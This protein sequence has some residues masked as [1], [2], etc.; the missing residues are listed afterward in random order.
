MLDKN[1]DKFSLPE[2]EERVL[3][4]WKE[5]RIF[6]K[7][8]EK[9]KGKKKF[10]FFEGPPT[11]NGRPG[12]HHVL[13]RSFKDLMPRYKTMRG[14]EVPRKAGWDT[15]G[16]P[17][18][19]QAEKELGLESKKDIDKYGIA[20]FNA[21][22]RE[23]VWRYRNEFEGVTD[24]MGFWIDMEDPYVTYDNRYVESLWWVISKINDRK[25]LV[26]GHRVAP[27][28]SRCGT[29][30]SSHE[31]AQGYKEKKSN[32]VYV[33]FAVKKGQKIGK[34]FVADDKTYL[35]S[36]TT[37][38][39]TLPGNVALAVGKNIDYKLV[40]KGDEKFI[41]SYHGGV[42][43]A[44]GEVDENIADLQ[45]KDLIGLSYKPLFDVK[46]L[47]NKKSHKVYA[48]D[49][50]TDNEG[51]GI[52]HTA[53]MYGEDDYALGV[54]ENLPQYHT[55]SED[56]KYKKDVVGFSGK[57]V[58]EA[59][60]EETI[61][62]FL[63]KNKAFLK[64]QEYPH[65]YPHCWRC[66]TPLLY[67]ARS[68]WFVQMSKLKKDLI[69]ANNKVSWT[70]SHIKQGRFGEWLKDVKDW[71]FSRARYWGTPLPIWE[72]LNTR[73]EHRQVVSGFSDLYKHR[74]STNSYFGLRHGESEHNVG[75]QMVAS[76]P[77]VK[78]KTSHLT[79]KGVAQAEEMAKK[80]KKEKIQVI[81]A[82]P[83]QR[84]QK[85]A[86][87]IAKATKAKVITDKRLGEWNTGVFNWKKHADF[88][89]FF[90]NDLERFT[91]APKGGETLTDIQSRAMEFI[92][93][94]DKKYKNKNILI[95]THADVLWLLEGSLRGLSTPEELLA[96]DYY[97]SV[98]GGY[99]YKEFR[100]PHL[101]YNEGGQVDV[102]RP[103]IDAVEL[104]CSKCK[105]NMRRVLELA[106]VWFDSGAMPLA[107]HQFPFV[108]GDN[109]KG[110]KLEEA[111]KKLDFPADYICEAIDQ[112]RGWF[113]TLLA[114]STLLER[115]L[116]YK[117]VV[118]LGL[119][120]DKNGIKMSKSKG[121]IVLP[122]EVMGKYGADAVRLYFYTMNH[123]G[124]AK[125][126]NE[127]ELAK[128]GRR[129]LMIIYNTYVFLKTYGTNDPVP[130][131]GFSPK[132]VL[133]RWIISSVGVLTNN[134]TKH[135]EAYEIGEAAR[136]MEDFLADLSR[137]YVRRSRSRFQEAA[138]GN[139][140]LEKDLREASTTLRYVLST[141]AKLMAPFTPFFAEALYKSVDSRGESVHLESW[142]SFEKKQIDQDLL[143]DMAIVR[144]V[145]A[146]ALAL[147]A[148]NGLKVR[149]PL[150][151]LS[152]KDTSLRGKKELLEILMEEVNVRTIKFSSAIKAES[153]ILL[154]TELTGELVE[155]GIIREL[156][157]MIQSL[158]AEAKY[159][160]G[161]EIVLMISAPEDLM[162][163]IQR[164][165]V[166]LKK[167]VNAKA[168]ELH[169]GA[170][171][172]AMIETKLKD[173]EISIAVR[174][175]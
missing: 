11:A 62:A 140:T 151:S 9:N 129:F 114:T 37:T 111:Y 60:T 150:A 33:K 109:L 76:G 12:I 64:V 136:L 117:N 107:A 89:A 30:L 74:A 135:L 1:P 52:V 54:S 25:L 139:I 128:V 163:L 138:R 104:K 72:C 44:L 3:K 92:L 152:L 158:R 160:M 95:V 82:S 65:E 27:W 122:M 123:P 41:A 48:A 101:P 75:T 126:F 19:I 78:G 134:I 169:I 106:D 47:Q 165:N 69:S 172:D 86:Q 17:V 96:S 43:N 100:A 103:Y 110:K 116:A 173:W 83:Y 87:I 170:K 127:D 70:P 171:K 42:A 4:F 153:G 73:C 121:N 148:E 93:E 63:K 34:D 162:S 7:S 35:L 40:K 130:E 22:C 161:E 81:F 84:S 164:R 29:A 120:H 36:W 80:L 142:P 156:A 143:K 55:V 53:V 32:S 115:G 24:R 68:S 145:A 88:T 85:T 118:C 98:D 97:P 57:S 49:F 10:V 159:E 131:S 6:Q 105:K 94:V 58:F 23:L 132:H 56:G 146:A 154:D 13:A 14:F 174:K 5:K 91:K 67:Y 20:K 112:T 77:E 66:S 79:A 90:K 71:N 166:A 28:C 147:R 51:T 18:E 168:I 119:V 157:R 61:F 99:G 2:L 144:S 113:Y 175:L 38:P 137:W 39:W 46:R 50:V 167:M 31:L 125:N 15:H 124:D 149:Q 108:Y 21:Y 45:G 26:K 141:L 133:D 155:E 16:L 102:H 8:L 59:K